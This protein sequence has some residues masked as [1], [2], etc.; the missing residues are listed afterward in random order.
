MRESETERERERR[1]AAS[2]QL[3]Q[4]RSYANDEWV[5]PKRERPP[6]VLLCRYRDV[7]E[8]AAADFEDR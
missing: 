8:A 2:N 7:V 6:L 4:A 1:P 3:N 5:R